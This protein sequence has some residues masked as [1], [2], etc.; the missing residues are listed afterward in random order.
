MEKKPRS[1][2]ACVYRRYIAVSNIEDQGSRSNEQH[3]AGISGRT[4]G[5][6]ERTVCVGEGGGEGEGGRSRE[7]GGMRRKKNDR[8]SR[9]GPSDIEA[10]TVLNT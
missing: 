4:S 2:T 8:K 9:T 3:A 6:N 7:K 1:T 5:L 10:K